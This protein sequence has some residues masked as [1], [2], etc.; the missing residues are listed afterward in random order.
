ML[1]V[2]SCLHLIP[3][4]SIKISLTWIIFVIYSFDLIFCQVKNT[5][6]FIKGR[7]LRIRKTFGIFQKNILYM[8]TA[9]NQTI[10]AVIIQFIY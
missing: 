1:R 2:Q 6:D 4:Q 7:Q 5:G 3:V 8:I 9:F 10:V